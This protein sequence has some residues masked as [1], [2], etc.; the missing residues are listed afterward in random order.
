MKFK[1]MVISGTPCSGKSTLARE[2]SKIYGFPIYSI[3]Q[4]FRERWARAYPDGKV[5]FEDY[6]RQTGLRENI[7]ADEEIFA[8]INCGNAIGD[9]RYSFRYNPETTLKVLVNAELSERSLRAMSSGRYPDKEFCEIAHTLK[10]REDQE[11]KTG[12]DMYGASYD[13]RNPLGYHVVLNSGILSV[14]REVGVVRSLFDLKE[15]K[16]PKRHRFF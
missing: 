3:G 16:A 14:D 12:Q 1:S 4:I 11:V 13:Y 10:G 8:K 6:W 15:K 2:L 7:E 5:S 9:F